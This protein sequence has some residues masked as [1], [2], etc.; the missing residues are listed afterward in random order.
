MSHKPSSPLS[1]TIP[2]LETSQKLTTAKNH[3]QLDSQIDDVLI[4]KDYKPYY[5][6]RYILE[7]SYK[8]SLLF[9]VLY[10]KKT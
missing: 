5:N 7:Y 8:A 2:S 4:P 3:S 6:K 1:I 9:I 10:Y